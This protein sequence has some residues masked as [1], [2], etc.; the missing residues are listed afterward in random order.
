M[1]E[2]KTAIYL[3]DIRKPYV[4][5]GEMETS[6]ATRIAQR[7]R[8]LK[9]QYGLTFLFIVPAG[10]EGCFGPEVE[11]M[12]FNRLR[13]ILFKYRV[14]KPFSS[15]IFPKVDLVHW[16]Q[17]MPKL[18]FRYSP[19]TLVT[20]H[21]INFI[22]NGIRKRKIRKRMRKLQRSLRQATH[23]S[24]ISR[25]TQQDVT[26]H[27]KITQPCRVI[28]NGVTDLSLLPAA[29]D[30]PLPA[31]FLFHLSGLGKKK[32]AHLLVEMMRFLPHEHL[33]IAG[34]GSYAEE[35]R[36]TDTIDRYQ[37]KNVSFIGLVTREEKA[38]L[39]HHCK[40]F[41]FPSLSEGFGLP[42]VEAMCF[43]KPTFISRF[44]SLPEVGGDVSH[45][46][47][48][49]QPEAMAKVVAEGLAADAA[50]GDR[51][52]QLVIQHSRQFDWGKAAD[53][54]I[55]YYLDILGIG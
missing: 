20:I 39:Y 15:L 28:M 38:W 37:L 11:Y 48:D 22:H 55:Q 7:A 26:A 51:K 8:G 50:A 36:I 33:V 49:L 17:Q 5:L 19:Y 12:K 13:E 2:H 54:Y 32:N 27:F 31:D 14:L 46:F 6:L 34:K 47:D 35:K 24:F 43:G 3:Y 16:C 42:V 45:Y 44:T 10:K 41:L 1:T 29:C 52:S 4:G 53:E 18:H 25:F 40:A 9:E 23:L 21:D 30:K